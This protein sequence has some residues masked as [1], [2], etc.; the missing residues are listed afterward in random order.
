MSGTGL[1]QILYGTLQFVS[2]EEMKYTEVNGDIVVVLMDIT[3]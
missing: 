1:S 2:T 3:G